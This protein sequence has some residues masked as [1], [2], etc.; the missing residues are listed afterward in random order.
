LDP[1]PL[2]YTLLKGQLDRLRESFPEGFSD[3]QEA[4]LIHLFFPYLQLLLLSFIPKE[5]PFQLIKPTTQIVTELVRNPNLICPLTKH[6]TLLAARTLLNLRGYSETQSEAE[7]NLT[8]LLE[9]SIMPSTWDQDIKN[10]IARGL[11]SEPQDA[12]FH[13]EQSRQMS[14]TA[15]RSLQHLAELATATTIENEGTQDQATEA[16]RLHG[17]Q[18]LVHDGYF[19]NLGQ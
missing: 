18:A 6:A 12:E 15:T 13:A 3:P 1:I 9:D 19:N 11:R 10:L 4:P 17:L 16:R 5:D 14:L 8:I 2:H 7:R